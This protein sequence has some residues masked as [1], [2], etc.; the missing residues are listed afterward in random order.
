MR[1]RGMAARWGTIVV[2]SAL[3]ATFLLVG[4]PARVG[5]PLTPSAATT[6]LCSGYSGCKDAGYSDAGYGAVS[7]KMYWQM[8]SGHN[9]TNYAAY[10]VIKSGGPATRPWTGGGNASEWGLRMA[11][12]T[13]QVPNV[14]AIAWWG[15]YSNGS[16]SAGH[17]AYVEKVVSSTEIIISEDSWGG[18]FHWR[19]ITKSSGRWPTGFIHFTDKTVAAKTPPTIVGTPAVGAVLTAG[20]ATWSVTPTSVHYNWLVDGVSTGVLT[21][22]FTPRVED[23]GKLVTLKVRAKRTGYTDGVQVSTPSPGVA[24]GTFV[25]EEPPVVEGTPYVDEVLTASTGTWLPAPGTVGWRWYADGVRVS[26][27]VTAKLPLT[28]ALVGKKITVIPVVRQDGYDA[29]LAP[30]VSAGQV[31]MGEIAVAR[32]S[33]ITGTPKVGATLTAADGAAVPADT[34]NTHQWLKD[35]RPIAGATAKTYKIKWADAGSKI[36]VQIGRTRK[37]YA[38]LTEKVAAT[39]VVT[40]APTLWITTD[41]RR[42]AAIVKVTVTSH[43]VEPVTGKVVVRIGARSQTVTLVDGRARVTLPISTPGRRD[44]IVRY[45]GSTVVPAA[46]KD[47]TVTV[48]R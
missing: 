1:N 12:I 10:R 9:C 25:L 3:F 29:A 36:S 19:T 26:G 41:G 8:Y 15:R 43:G 39:G 13:D 17:V 23:L 47:S 44:V 6:Y 42:G 18:T 11:S 30:E 7:S 31:L 38:P 2:T 27:N 32:P 46:R 4:S 28:T 16:G 5:V 14:G 20:P 34:T 24:K 21:S 40:S 22:T 37:N 45:L 33:T 48:P 35:G